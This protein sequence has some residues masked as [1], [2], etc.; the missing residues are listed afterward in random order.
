MAHECN[1]GMGLAVIVVGLDRRQADGNPRIVQELILEPHGHVGDCISVCFGEIRP[2]GEKRGKF[3]LADLIGV[4]A[5]LQKE[6]SRVVLVA[7]SGGTGSR[8]EIDDRECGINTFL[9]LQPILLSLGSQVVN[10]IEHDLIKVANSGVEVA[11]DCNIE[12]QCEAI[13]PCSLHA[14]I[15]FQRHDRL[16]GSSGAD[17]QI[18]R[19]E[20]LAK[21]LEGHDLT[22]P[23]GCHLY[24]PL[25][26]A[27]G[28]ENLPWLECFE[29]LQG[30]FAHL[31]G[32][33]YENGLI[34][35]RVKDPLGQIDGDACH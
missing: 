6:Q 1:D 14:E 9:P 18:S 28:Y 2:S 34:G 16:G 26:V 21:L 4:I 32:T 17:H 29:M 8:L 30:Q 35:E 7:K 19:D 31:A 15:L 23:P 12:D 24:G 20:C 22:V 10:V 3:A 33:N 11:R 27:I 25:R 5:E 13:T